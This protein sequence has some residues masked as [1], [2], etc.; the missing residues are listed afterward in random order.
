MK[1]KIR[2]NELNSVFCLR[3]AAVLAA[4]A[5]RKFGTV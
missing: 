4:V 5:G 2:R 1:L 3:G